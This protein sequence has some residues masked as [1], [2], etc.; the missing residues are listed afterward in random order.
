MRY[1]VIV[2]VDVDARTSE[3]AEREAL[4]AIVGDIAGWN[5]NVIDVRTEIVPADDE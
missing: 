1:R 5:E 4:K 3:G 2:T